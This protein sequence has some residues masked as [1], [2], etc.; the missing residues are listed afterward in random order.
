MR[1][2]NKTI[3][4][5]FRMFPGDIKRFTALTL[6]GMMIVAVLLGSFHH[7]DDLDDHPD[8]SICAVAHHQPS[9]VA[10]SP[11]YIPPVR[12]ALSVDYTPY[13]ARFHSTAAITSQSRAPP[14]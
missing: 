7:H 8:C 13:T 6:S 2:G 3:S 9:C 12:I 1:S 5:I 11:A 14:A 10:I 4:N